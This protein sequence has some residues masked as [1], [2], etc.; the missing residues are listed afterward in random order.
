MVNSPVI[1][2]EL[3]RSTEPPQPVRPARQPRPNFPSRAAAWSVRHRRTAIGGWVLFVVIATLLGR[4]RSLEDA[5]D[6]ARRFVRA[7]L[8]AAPGFGSGHGPLGHAGARS[9]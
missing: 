6:G 4:G 1:T 7:A 5:I 9:D 8:E 3:N 2:T